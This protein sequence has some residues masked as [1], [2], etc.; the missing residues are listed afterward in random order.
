[1]AYKLQTANVMRRM[2]IVGKESKTLKHSENT[3]KKKV[4]IPII[5]CACLSEQITHKLYF[6]FVLTFLLPP[7]LSVF[8]LHQNLIPLS[9]LIIST[10]DRCF[11][12]CLVGKKRSLKCSLMVLLLQVRTTILFA[13]CS[14][15]VSLLSHKSLQPMSR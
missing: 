12:E 1:M 5:N 11:A 3:T 10:P 2:I 9:Q 4:Q 6:F 13:K 7:S 14:P 15:T 8:L